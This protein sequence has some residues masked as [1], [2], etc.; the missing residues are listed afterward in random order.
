M[1]DVVAICLCKSH[2]GGDVFVAG[3][4]GVGDVL[5]MCGW[6][7]CCVVV[8]VACVWCVCDVCAMCV[9]DVLSMCWLCYG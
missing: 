1:H 9:C 7:V 8:V 5:A 6:C 3:W 2:L 4:Q